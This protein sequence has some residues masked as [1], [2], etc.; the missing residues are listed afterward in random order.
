[1]KYTLYNL[2]KDPAEKK[3][4]AGDNQDRVDTMKQQLSDWQTSVI[5]SLNGEDYA[6]EASAEQE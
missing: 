6:T 2:K 3:D 5:E 1:M 4:V